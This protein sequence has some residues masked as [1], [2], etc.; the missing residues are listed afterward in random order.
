MMSTGA[1]ESCLSN[2]GSAYAALQRKPIDRAASRPE[3]GGLHGPGQ[4]D[5]WYER[6]HDPADAR[7]HCW[8]STYEERLT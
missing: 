6:R 4:G 8:C 1:I 2:K 3:M 5:L 7:I